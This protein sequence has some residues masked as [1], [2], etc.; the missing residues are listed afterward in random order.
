ME[1]N[2][3]T[4]SLDKLKSL[5]IDDNITGEPVILNFEY[6]SGWRSIS[7]IVNI[8]DDKDP[9]YYVKRNY[10]LLKGDVQPTND[11]KDKARFVELLKGL[12]F[13]GNETQEEGLSKV[14]DFFLKKQLTY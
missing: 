4:A 10:E 11:E 3:V 8:M 2:K 12:C 7:A 5:G 9:P 14:V 1:L 13:S 6:P